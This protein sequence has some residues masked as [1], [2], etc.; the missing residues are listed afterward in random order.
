[1]FHWFRKHKSDGTEVPDTTPDE[2]TLTQMPKRPFTIQEQIMRF[3][4][5]A[6]F[7]RALRKKGLDT[8][9]DADD[10]EVENDDEPQFAT[11]PYELKEQDAFPGLQT[12]LDEV[13]GGAVRDLHPDRLNR[14]TERLKGVRRD[15]DGKIVGSDRSDNG[16]RQPILEK[17]SGSGSGGEGK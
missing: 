7:E 4:A 8:F 16:S 12:R 14:A 10:L 11:T 13:K 2:I 15:V 9:E 6:D 5:A 17:T 1:M 3:T